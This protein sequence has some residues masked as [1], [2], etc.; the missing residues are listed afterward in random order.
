MMLIA[1]MALPLFHHGFSPWESVGLLLLGLLI[2]FLVGY[3]A[4]KARVL[5][6]HGI[7][8]RWKWH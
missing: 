4:A 1:L 3:F 5:E 7:E 6:R 2:G 8:T